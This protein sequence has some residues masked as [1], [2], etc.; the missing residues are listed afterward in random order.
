M[1]Y[2]YKHTFIISL[3]L[4]TSTVELLS[5]QAKSKTTRIR[6]EYFE[7]HDNTQNLLA[8]ILVREKSYV[9]LPDVTLHFYSVK[10]DTSKILLD[11]IQT[12]NQGQIIFTIQDHHDIFVDSLGIMTFEVEFNGNKLYKKAKRNIT[13][14]QANLE[15]SFFQKD[16]SKFIEVYASTIGSDNRSIPLESTDIMFYIKGTF[17]LLN[18]GQEKTNENGKAKIEFPV[19]MPG[20]STGMLTIIVKIEEHDDYGTLEA[21]GVINWGKAIVLDVEKHRGLGDTDAPLWMVYTLIILLSAVWFHYLYVVFLIIKIKLE[22][23]TLR[24][25]VLQGEIVQEI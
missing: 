2:L 13:V 1:I 16:T 20:D 15:V 4:L 25:K 19:D 14:K 18:I 10:N 17:S 9:P 3:I 22:E 24:S 8:T 5:Q 7:N 21:N 23:K 11:K 6:L 12:N